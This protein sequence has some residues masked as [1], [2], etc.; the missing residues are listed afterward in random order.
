MSSGKARKQP[1]ALFFY[2]QGTAQ[3]DERQRLTRQT[4]LGLKILGVDALNEIPKLVDEVV[5]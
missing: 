3:L 1:L 2:H 4:D 5:R